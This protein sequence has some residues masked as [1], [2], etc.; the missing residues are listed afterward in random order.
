MAS[1]N[2]YASGAGGASGAELATVSPLLTSGHIWYVN[3]TTTGAADAVSPAGREKN[4]PLL[5]LAQ[6]HTNASAGDII[7]IGAGH[8]QTLTAEQ[9]FDKAN[10]L[11]IGEGSSN[12]TWPR[13][14][15]NGNIIMFNVTAAGVQFRNLRFPASGTATSAAKVTLV[16]DGTGIADCYFEAGTNDDG[17]QITIAQ[18]GGV[19]NLFIR[20][21]TI[22][23]TASA[24]SDQPNTGII[25]TNTFSRLEMDGVVFNGGSSGWAYP[26]ACSIEAAITS[27]KGMN[28]E[29]LN[30]S[31]VSFSTGTTG[32]FHV[33]RTSGS[34]RVVWTA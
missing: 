4:K 31:D 14:T 25:S 15:R 30:D 32:Y 16:G 33:V 27:I 6:A 21:T 28:I 17:S 23:S 9:T 19:G 34:S 3:N 18:S 24:P 13:F 11:V 12:A 20:D 5:T 8:T 7:F 10:I 2:F 26:W 1:P 29:L 22:I